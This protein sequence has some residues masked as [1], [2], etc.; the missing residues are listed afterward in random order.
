MK[1]VYHWFVEMNWN[2]YLKLFGVCWKLSWGAGCEQD[3]STL[4][5]T[6]HFKNSMRNYYNLPLG[7]QVGDNP[8]TK[9][10]YYIVTGKQPNQRG[11]ICR[12]SKTLGKN[13]SPIHTPSEINKA[14]LP[15]DSLFQA[16][17]FE[18]GLMLPWSPCKITWMFSFLNFSCP[19]LLHL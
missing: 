17:I 14:L 7:T 9:S 16:L 6:Y 3:M 19:G 13:T 4:P 1:T 2:G 18:F 10:N 8:V 5:E 11:L 15:E 12:W